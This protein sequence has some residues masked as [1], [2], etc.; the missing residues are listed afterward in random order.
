M[1]LEKVV[2]KGAFPKSLLSTHLLMHHEVAVRTGYWVFAHRFWRARSELLCTGCLK[3]PQ[4]VPSTRRMWG[5]CEEHKVSVSTLEWPGGPLTAVLG[6]RQGTLCTEPKR[7]APGYKEGV[8]RLQQ[9]IAS[10]RRVPFPTPCMWP[11][12]DTCALYCSLLSLHMFW[13]AA[14]DLMNLQFHTNAAIGVRD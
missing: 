6:K 5:F 2:K 7:W 9:T 11:S 10:Q 4:T 1:H 14:A 13:E 12:S 8:C 3:A